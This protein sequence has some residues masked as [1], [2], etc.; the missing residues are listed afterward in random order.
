MVA[1]AVAVAGAS[2]NLIDSSSG[3]EVVKVA[4]TY[5]REPSSNITVPRSKMGGSL[6]VNSTEAFS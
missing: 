5:T 6:T 1:V 3:E 2:G 4:P